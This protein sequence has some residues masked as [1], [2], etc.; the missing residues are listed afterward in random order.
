MLSVDSLTTYELACL[1]FL[2]MLLTC[3]YCLA[4]QSELL[5]ADTTRV[6]TTREAPLLG[7]ICWYYPARGELWK[8]K[9]IQINSNIMFVS[10]SHPFFLT[11]IEN[12]T[13]F[14]MFFTT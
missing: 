6:P 5:V 1:Y 9:Y 7:T 4:N 10:L 11:F 14:R 12:S 13:W 3:P 2:F 8:I